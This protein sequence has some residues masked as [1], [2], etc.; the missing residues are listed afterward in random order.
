M[1]EQ[2]EEEWSALLEDVVATYC[3]HCLKLKPCILEKDPYLI[4]LDPE[5]DDEEEYWCKP[6][7][8]SRKD[9]I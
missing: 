3:D 9:D 4:V 8:I 5:N 6:C 7:Y 2:S 1:I